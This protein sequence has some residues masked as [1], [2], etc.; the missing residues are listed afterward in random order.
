MCA[1]LYTTDIK[2]KSDEDIYLLRVELWG[3]V[4]YIFSHP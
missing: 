1:V 4:M 3:W 2:K